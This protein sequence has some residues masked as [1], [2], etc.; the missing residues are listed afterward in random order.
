MTKQYRFE[1]AKLA[2]KKKFLVR[3]QARIARTTQRHVN[4]I[5][6]AAVRD[7]RALKKANSKLAAG[8]EKEIAIITKRQSILVG[9]LS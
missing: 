9:R 5:E 7:I 1:L 6:I 2:K 3:S 4:K 8:L